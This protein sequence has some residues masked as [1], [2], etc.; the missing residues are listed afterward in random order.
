M[1]NFGRE[2]WKGRDTMEYP[3]ED[4]RIILKWICSKQSG[5]EADQS[6]Q[7]RADVKNEWRTTF[8]PPRLHSVMPNEAEGHLYLYSYTI[9]VTLY[10]LPFQEWLHDAPPA[11]LGITHPSHGHTL[12]FTPLTVITDT[13]NIKQFYSSRKQHT[14]LSLLSYI[15]HSYMSLLNPRNNKAVYITSETSVRTSQ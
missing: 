14:H 4:S 10:L 7:S 1:K 5:R 9:H 11:A 12:G 6:T 8:I 15:E 13:W 3:G 2:T